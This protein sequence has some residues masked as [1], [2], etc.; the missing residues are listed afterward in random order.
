MLNLK[1]ELGRNLFVLRKAYGFNHFRL[2]KLTGLTRPILSTIENASGNP[3]LDTLLKL[4]KTLE[5]DLN[6]LLFTKREFESYQVIL[7]ETFLKENSDEN[8]FIIHEKTWRELL[9]LSGTEKKT[10]QGRIAIICKEL[11]D[12]NLPELSSA[13][14]SKVILL[15][16]LGVIFQQDGF[17]FGLEFGAWLAQKL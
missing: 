1:F 14:R 16:V 5:I 12:Q 9:R 13:N 7:K 4:S 11:I 8:H 10:E 6:F 17:Q 15:S 2:V 3:T